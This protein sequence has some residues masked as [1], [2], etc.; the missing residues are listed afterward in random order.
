MAT[1]CRDLLVCDG[2]DKQKPVHVSVVVVPH[3][4]VRVLGNVSVLDLLD[5]S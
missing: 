1:K 4:R 2:V 5:I 3:T